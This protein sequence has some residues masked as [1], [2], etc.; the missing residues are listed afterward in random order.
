[1]SR[2][3]KGLI[4]F[5]MENSDGTQEAAIDPENAKWLKKVLTDASVDLVQQLKEDIQML[6]HVLSSQEIA[7]SDAHVILEDMLS[8]TED[9]DLAND[10]LKM[11]GARIMTEL[12]A[13]GPQDLKA[14]A[15]QLLANVTQNNPKAQE[16]CLGEKILEKLILQLHKESDRDCL[17]KLLLGISCLTRG[18]PPGVSAF[19]QADGFE[20]VLDLLDHLV[21]QAGRD[22][23]TDVEKV[24]AKGAF[25][26]YC[27]L[28]EVLPS[29]MD[30]GIEKSL[31][32]KLVKIAMLVSDAQE[33]LLAS[34]ILLLTDSSSIDMAIDVENVPETTL[35]RTRSLIGGEILTTFKTWLKLED[36]KIALST[37]PAQAELRSYLGVLRHLLNR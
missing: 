25:L 11:G 31:A 36:D 14:D 34:L 6:S 29:K 13:N 21:S 27:L 10:F 32:S 2:D 19:Q 24:C 16:I 26:I 8:L 17:K 28:Q 15:Y 1:M 5:A 37:D 22:E 18:Y 33:H 30:E 3:L 35:K 9:I 4:R 20:N 23:M 7:T 12:L